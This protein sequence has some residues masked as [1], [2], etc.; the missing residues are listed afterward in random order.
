MDG[1]GY[2]RVVRA[3]TDVEFMKKIIVFLLIIGALYYVGKS[4]KFSMGR[5]PGAISDPVYAVVRFRAEIH[6]RTFDMVALAKTFDQ[7]DC[8]HGSDDLVDRMQKREHQNGAPV[9]QLVSSECKSVLDS[10]SARLF[11]NKP[12]FVNYVS[13]TPGDSSEREVRLIFWGVTAQEGDIM[14]SEVPRMQE[15]WKGVVTCIHALPSQ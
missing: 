15:R 1:S 6:D 13:A 12:T 9:W 10:R 3:K 14:C 4:W 2:S 5:D 8:Q 7:E 11:D